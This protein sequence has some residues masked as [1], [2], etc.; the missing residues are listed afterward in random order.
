MAYQDLVTPDA[1]KDPG[2]PPVNGAGGER[3]SS[4]FAGND[5]YTAAGLLKANVI[6]SEGPLRGTQYFNDPLKVR[7]QTTVY[8][9]G[10]TNNFTSQDPSAA[11]NAPT[12]PTP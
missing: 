3:G 1:S 6:P 8:T 12:P 10:D 4:A 5:E 2:T 7:S 11:D 9:Q